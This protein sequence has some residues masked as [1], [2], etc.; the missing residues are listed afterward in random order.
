MKRISYSFLVLFLLATAVA[1]QAAV[2]GTVYQTANVRSGPGTH[3]EIVGQLG[4]G[5]QVQIDGQ[6]AD[7]R[8]LHVLL[9]DGDSGWLPVFS[10][11]TDANLDQIPVIEDEGTPSAQADVHVISYG[12]VNVRSGPGIGYEIVGQLDVN[13]RTEAIARS[14]EMNDWLMIR[15]GDGE[16]WVAYFTVDVQGDPAALPVLVP[17]SSGTSLIPPSRL[18]SVRFNVRLHGQPELESPVL[19]I[20]PF[21]NQVTAIARSIDGEWLYVGFN[22]SRGW[23]VT[24]LF[25]ISP[26]ELQD[27]P[28]LERG[29]ATPT[30]QPASTQQP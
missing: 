1:A 30:P 5:D 4:A 9:P 17:D 16:G 26:E 6:S 27:L 25:D 14:N 23:G 20:V 13:Q 21:N 15:L 28:V 12:R 24:P 29:T 11:I 8:W 22:D 2:F 10:L 3:F 19:L 18:V 7:Q